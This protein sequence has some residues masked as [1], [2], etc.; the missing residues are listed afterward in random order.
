MI[1]AQRYADAVRP[2]L[3]RLVDTQAGAVDRAADLIAAVHGMD[4]AASG[5][6]RPAG[7][8]IR[9]VNPDTGVGL[10]SATQGVITFQVSTGAGQR[11][12][13]ILD[14]PNQWV[15]WHEIAH[16]YQNRAYRWEGM[17]E[18]QGNLY[19]SHAQRA[20]GLP[21]RYTP[22]H[23]T[24]KEAQALFARPVEE[25][26]ASGASH[27]LMFEQLAHA[28]GSAF[29]P[30][31]NQ[32]YRVLGAT[33]G[34]ALDEDDH[35]IQQFIRIASRTSGHDLSEFFRQ[36]GLAA[37]ATTLE[38]VRPLADLPHPIW[39]ELDPAAMPLVRD[40]PAYVLPTG[41]LDGAGLPDVTSGWSTLP[42]GWRDR[43]RG[44]GSI[45]GTTP[46]RTG[47]A[48]VLTGSTSGHLWVELVSDSGV[49]E[50]LTAPLVVGRGSSLAFRGIYD[51]T[52]LTVALAADTSTWAV[53]FTE[54]ATHD[55]FGDQRFLGVELVGA[56]GLV[57]A[58]AS[59]AGNESG[60]AIA[61]A[62]HGLPAEDGQYLRVF[63]GEPRRLDLY[64]DGTAQARATTPDQAFRVAGGQLHRVAADAVAA[65]PVRPAVPGLNATTATLTMS[66]SV[67]ENAS[68]HVV[69]HG[70]AYAFEIH[71]GTASYGR[72]TY[73]PA[74]D[75]VTVTRFL[76]AGKG[77]LS[78]HR[79][80][81]APGDPAGG[82]TLVSTHPTVTTQP[83][84]AQLRGVLGVDVTPSTV[85][86]RLSGDALA[87]DV[88]HLVF[89]NG[90]YVVGTHQGKHYGSQRTTTGSTVR[91]TAT[92]PRLS[93]HDVVEVRLASGLPGDPQ[94]G[95]TAHTYRIT[96]ADIPIVL[97]PR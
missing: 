69:R 84:S 92:V 68:R 67:Y 31:L 54:F 26:A 52:P 27:E 93:A 13:T 30:R 87:S 37:D 62:L 81:G 57:I 17:A 51:R 35:K 10:A 38:A 64:V 21:T 14:A 85:T 83:T 95:V 16:T 44:V 79:V 45:D 76:P 1:S 70:G 12:L 4:P 78:L 50:V 43:V 61:R 59:A 34:T 23:A 36:W 65:P 29:Y 48:G 5:V 24:V 19:A 58:S 42:A 33:V 28:F 71:R 88:R 18:V 90:T 97:T 8:R 20:L 66:A 63:H 40:T 2:V 96:P 75:T 74:G 6:A 80:A 41:T 3:A 15:L 7:H 25:R 60:R 11:L 94:Y 77:D 86:L 9:I 55:T 46:A 47:A 39:T 22:A 91:F 72:V 73:S 49:R 82:G 56:D 53:M 32:E 89:V